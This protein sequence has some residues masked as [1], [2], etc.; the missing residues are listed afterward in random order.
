MA[1]ADT[2]RR[3][4]AS[5]LDWEQAHASLDHAIDGLAPELRGKRPANFPHSAGLS[6]AEVSTALDVL[7]GS[8]AGLVLTEVNPDH[9]PDGAVLRQLVGVLTNALAYSPPATRSTAPVQ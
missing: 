7:C 2:W 8:A 1:S 5:S 9:D 3:I 4:V 6:L